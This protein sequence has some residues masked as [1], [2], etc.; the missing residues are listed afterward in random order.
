[1]H[2]YSI[3]TLTAFRPLL[4]PVLIFLSEVK[5]QLP[6]PRLCSTATDFLLPHA[7]YS[8]LCSTYS[9]C[10]ME[11]DRELPVIE[12]TSKNTLHAQVVSDQ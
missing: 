6:V 9:G 2:A 1:M 11:T 12:A 7:Y 3:A 10:R 4:S 5:C 8:S